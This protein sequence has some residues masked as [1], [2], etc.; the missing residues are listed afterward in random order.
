[1]HDDE[2]IFK[3]RRQEKLHPILVTSVHD[4]VR[5]EAAK[6]RR[7]DLRIQAELDEKRKQETELDYLAPFLAQIGD[8]TSL[9]RLD[10]SSSSTYSKFIY[11]DL[12]RLWSVCK[13]TFASRLT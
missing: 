7:E 10:S 4:T 1:M 13:S 12:M 9:N 5:N 8:P 2:N 3:L 11:A 6:K